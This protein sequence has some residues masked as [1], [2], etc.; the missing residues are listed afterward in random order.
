MIRS[1]SVEYVST[2]GTPAGNGRKYGWDAKPPVLNADL[3]MWNGDACEGPA[4]SLDS[5]LPQWTGAPSVYNT[6]PQWNPLTLS[7]SENPARSTSPA[8]RPVVRALTTGCVFALFVMIL[9][10]SDVSRVHGRVQ[11]G[12]AV[13]SISYE[14]SSVQVGGVMRTSPVVQ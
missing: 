7:N 5:G 8:A 6:P 3:P 10:A 9:A 2:V 4:T 1:E 14:Q 12:R 11:A 13:S